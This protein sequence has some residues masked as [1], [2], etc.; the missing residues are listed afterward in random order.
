MLRVGV[1]VE[2][3]MAGDEALPL[4]GRVRAL[5]FFVL[6][7]PQGGDRPQTRRYAYWL[8]EGGPHFGLCSLITLFYSFFPTRWCVSPC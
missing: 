7:C 2:V 3:E 6:F 4:L 5:L 8:G 1:G